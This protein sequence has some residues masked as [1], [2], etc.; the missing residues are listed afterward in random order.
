MDR[1]YAPP[2]TAEQLFKQDELKRKSDEEQKIL[3]PSSRSDARYAELF[4]KPHPW[5]WKN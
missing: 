2:I 3:A 4:G 5:P 1:Y